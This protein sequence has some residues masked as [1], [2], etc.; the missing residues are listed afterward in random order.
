LEAR[1]RASLKVLTSRNRGVSLERMV[2][3]INMRTTGWV[4]Y[5]ALV[6]YP[7]VFKQCKRAIG[8]VRF[9]RACGVW[10]TAAWS[11]AL[12]GKGWWRLANTPQH[13]A[14]RAVEVTRPPT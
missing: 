2:A 8:I 3:Q 6:H 7:S 9:L 12:S 4:R 13:S 5:F 14:A 1:L 10:P 11:V